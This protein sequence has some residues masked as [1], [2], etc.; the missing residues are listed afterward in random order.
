VGVGRRVAFFL[1]ILSGSP[2]AF[3]DH[4]FW[5]PGGDEPRRYPFPRSKE[6]S[7]LQER[8]RLGLQDLRQLQRAQVTSHRLT[9]GHLMIEP[10]EEIS[11]GGRNAGQGG[12][13]KVPQ[14][15]EKQ[16]PLPG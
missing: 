15:K 1:G 6:D 2:S 12:G 3:I 13:L 10:A 4:R 14:V 16:G 8:P 5:H 9:E 11:V 7:F